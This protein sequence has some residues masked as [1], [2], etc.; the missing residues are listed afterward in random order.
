MKKLLLILLMVSFF[1]S[2]GNDDDR[3]ETEANIVASWKLVD[4]YDTEPRDINNDGNASTDLY[5]QWNGCFKQ[6]TLVLY[7]DGSARK[8]YT[9]PNNNSKCPP[10]FQTGDFHTTEPWEISETE[11]TL[12]FFG[13]DYLDVYEI[14]EMTSTELILAGSGFLTC[15]DEDIS[16]FTGGYLKFEAE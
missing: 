12:T 6:S 13:D 3:K 5:S 11:Q 8:V 2:C 7:D 16:F 15:C 4:W 14:M 10:D 9:G 1:W